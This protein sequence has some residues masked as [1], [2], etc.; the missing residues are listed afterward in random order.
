V[1]TSNA[2][3]LVADATAIIERIAGAE[4]VKLIGHPDTN[5]LGQTVRLI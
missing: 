1:P 4:A 2:K 3:H 5:F